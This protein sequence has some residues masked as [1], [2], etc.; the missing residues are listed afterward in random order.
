MNIKVNNSKKQTKVR[1]GLPSLLA[2]CLLVLSACA[3]TQKVDIKQSGINCA[4]LANKCS[5]LTSGSKDQVG[6]RY[7]NTTSAAQWSQYSKILIDPV[8]F[9]AGDSTRLSAA[10]QQMLVNYTAQQLNEQL[11]QKFEIVNQAGPGVIKIDVAL[12]DAD[13]ATPVLRTISM[14]VPQARV[15]STLKYLATGSMPFVGAAQVEAKLTDSVT[16]QILVMAVDRRIGGGSFTT[17]FQWKWGD[18]QNAID[19][20]AELLT[21]RLSAWTSGTEPVQ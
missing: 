13:S 16:G 1:A 21:Q 14:I 15:L 9:W 8:T 7:V 5:L 18:A 4:F 19:H 17:A 20:W 6:L 12:T 10:D 11:G 3:T 2:V